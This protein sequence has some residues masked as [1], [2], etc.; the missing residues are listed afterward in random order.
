MEDARRIAVAAYHQVLEDGPD[1]CDSESD[2]EYS[3]HG[4]QW[5]Y[6]DTYTPEMLRPDGKPRSWPQVSST[7]QANALRA[8][9]RSKAEAKPEPT[10]RHMSHPLMKRGRWTRSEPCGTP[11][12]RRNLEGRGAKMQLEHQGKPWKFHTCLKSCSL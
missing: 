4:E 8:A 1:M 7:A 12:R 11:R 2:A 3:D 10:P 6:S 9:A 5:S